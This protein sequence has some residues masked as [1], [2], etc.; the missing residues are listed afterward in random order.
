[1]QYCHLIKQLEEH[2][3]SI[4]L[5]TSAA[6]ILENSRT[7]V[8]S[9]ILTIEGPA[10][11]CYDVDMLVPLY[12]KGFRISTL[13]WNE[14][15]CLAGSHISGGKLTSK[16]ADY[17]RK[18]QQLG[19]LIDVSHLSDSAFW[20]IIELTQGPIIASHSNSRTIYE[21]TRNISDDMFLAICR[22]GGVTG[23]NLYAELLGC[24][25][26]LDTVCDH[27]F[28]FLE[29]EPSGKHISLGGD[30]DGCNCLPYGFEGI[31][32]YC[33]LADRLLARGLPYNTVYDI[34]WNNALGVIERCCT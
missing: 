33:L 1:M 20:D 11:F 12:E 21:A 31:Q 15:N 30:L 32:S 34:F 27:I 29:L 6:D 25:A 18:A 9:A 7:G 5:A 22:T 10:G 4:R 13:G 23:I 26:S 16:G 2:K 8:M 19:M 28:H 14:D 3:D 17:V 24:N